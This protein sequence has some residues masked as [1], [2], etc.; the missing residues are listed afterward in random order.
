[1]T[2]RAPAWLDAVTASPWTSSLALLVGGALIGALAIWLVRPL[3]AG[4]A[5]R[6][7][8]DWDDAAV[9]L[10]WTPIGAAL[11]VQ[12]MV[13]ASPA[14]V[15]R[16][17]A[18]LVD[19]ILAVAVRISALWIA[20]RAVDAV[21]SVLKQRAKAVGRPE[22][23]ALIGI[24]ARLL[25]VLIVVAATVTVLGRLGISARSLVAGL[26]LGGLAVALAARRTLENL[27]GSVAI[28]VDQPLHVGDRIRVADLVGVVESVGL[29]STRIRTLD[30]TLVTIPNGQ[31]ANS[32]IEALTA[33]DRTRLVSVLGLRHDTTADQLREI[34]TGVEAVLRGHPKIWSEH[35]AV[36]LVELSA[37]SIDLEILAWFQTT[38][39]DE[40]DAIRHDVLLA[41]VEVIA[42]SGAALA[43]QGTAMP[44]ARSRSS[45]AG[46]TGEPRR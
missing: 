44:A 9:A 22:S 42:R 46:A 17:A 35:V 13:A 40:F 25:K 30:R 1:M 39:V 31:L 12:G 37:W 26:G 36:Q 19:P 41:I 45:S 38:D 4:A 33:R 15:E 14:L 34:V 3:L 11:V 29:R 18:R 8:T 2:A 10:L 24:G 32:R 6:T 43:D 21:R 16:P 23:L 28:G 20:F 5:R 27:F 7:E